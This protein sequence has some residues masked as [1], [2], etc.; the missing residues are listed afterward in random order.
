[1]S[2]NPKPITSEKE[3]VELFREKFA[4]AGFTGKAGF[5]VV[6]IEDAGKYYTDLEAFISQVWNSAYSQGEQ[7]TAKGI[8]KII[9]NEEFI[10]SNPVGQ[11]MLL[12]NITKKIDAIYLSGED[13]I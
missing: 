4:S 5:G 13:K 11:L 2:N 8:K 12:T 3:A 7:A 9:D 10:G 6:R 1:M